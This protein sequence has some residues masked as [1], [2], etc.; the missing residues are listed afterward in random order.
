V[1][2]GPSTVPGTLTSASFTPTW[3]WSTTNILPGHIIYTNLGFTIAN[4]ISQ[5]GSAEVI[6]TDTIDGSGYDGNTT[7]DCWLHN[8][9]TY[10]VSGTTTTAKCKSVN[11]K[12]ATISDLPEVAANQRFSHSHN[13]EQ[14]GQ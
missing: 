4:K 11:S 6:Y 2:S 14:R 5:G 7:D 13:E 3:G 8:Y 9:L 12:T 10:T 1:I